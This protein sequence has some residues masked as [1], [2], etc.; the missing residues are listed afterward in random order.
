MYVWIRAKSNYWKSLKKING[1]F[2][3]L[4]KAL[5]FKCCHVA[6]NSCSP[7]MGVLAAS[8]ARVGLPFFRLMASS[9]LIDA[10]T[11]T[12]TT[13]HRVGCVIPGVDVLGFRNSIQDGQWHRLHHCFASAL[14]SPV[15]VVL[16]RKSLFSISLSGCTTKWLIVDLI[17]S[18]LTSIRRLPLTSVG[19]GSDYK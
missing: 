10:H 13:C 9:V 6:C 19:R 7:K 4:W 5:L 14:L 11:I 16:I 1:A 8:L 2:E 15:K 3:E 12:A 17:Q 18:P